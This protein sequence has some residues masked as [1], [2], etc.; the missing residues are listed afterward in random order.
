MGG[1]P[2]RLSGRQPKAVRLCGLCAAV[3][4]LLSTGQRTFL[5]QENREANN[6]PEKEPA[7]RLWKTHVSARTRRKPTSAN[8]PANAASNRPPIDGRF[9]VIY[10]FSTAFCFAHRAFCA[11]EIAAL[12]FADI[13][14]RFRFVLPPTMMIPLFVEP[15][16]RPGPRLFLEPAGRPRL[17]PLVAAPPPVSDA[18]AART[19]A[20]CASSSFSARRSPSRIP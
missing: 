8:Q 10:F 17:R 18:T 19:P 4:V 15:A 13:L 16:G 5:R 14:R 3:I 1:I 11:F 9:D 20:S 7:P 2:N 6:H 12:A